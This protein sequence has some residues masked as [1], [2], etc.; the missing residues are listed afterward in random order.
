M[1]PH[2]I[3]D[4]QHQPVPEPMPELV[5]LDLD[6]QPVPDSHCFTCGTKLVQ[7]CGYCSACLDCMAEGA[8]R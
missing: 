7:R 8:G 6:R 5:L 4:G 1:T 2:P 3:V